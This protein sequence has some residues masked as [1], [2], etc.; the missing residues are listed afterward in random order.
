MD[1]SFSVEAAQKVGITSAVIMRYMVHWTRYNALNGLHCHDG[2]Y[3]TYNSATALAATFPYVSLQTIKRCLATM[4]DEG[5]LM[6]RNDL[7]SHPYDRTNWYCATEKSFLLNGLSQNESMVSAKTD[8]QYLLNNTLDI[9][10][11]EREEEPAVEEPPKPKP[12][13]KTE[14]KSKFCKEESLA[15]FD[16]FWR[17]YPKRIRKQLAK[18]AWC[19]QKVTPELFPT[20]MDGL[21]RCIACDKRFRD[22]YYPNPETWINAREW[23]NEYDIPRPEPD[24]IPKNNG[25]D[26]IERLYEEPAAP[27]PER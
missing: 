23:E 25:F 4:V 7:N 22:G 8:Q 15:L 3:W 19:K 6:V 9:E 18:Q 11:I 17:A 27:P 1:H 12:K 2:M 13:P 14:P 26:A 5:Y 20:V 16:T 21:R 24:Q 10:S